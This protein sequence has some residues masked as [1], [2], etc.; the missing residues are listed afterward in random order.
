MTEADKKE[1]LSILLMISELYDKTMHKGLMKIWWE[2]L[3]EY[4]ITAVSAAFKKYRTGEKGAFM[5]KPSDFISLIRGNLS[6]IADMQ[7]IEVLDS[8]RLCGR[9]SRPQF[10]DKIT[11][12]VISDMGGWNSLCDMLVADHLPRSR[13]FARKY[14]IRA[15]H[16]GDDSEILSLSEMLK[17]VGNGEGRVKYIENDA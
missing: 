1:F 15:T 13:E 3:K 9:G 14:K 11:D 7:W 12:Q 5:P 4:E 6:D 10:Q 17:T 8:V 2:D 16:R